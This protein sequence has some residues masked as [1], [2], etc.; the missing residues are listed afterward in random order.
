MPRAG[1]TGSGFGMKE[2]YTPCSIATSLITSRK[3]M[4]LSAVRQRVGV[5]Q[6]DLLLARR[7]LVVAELHRDAHRLE[8]RDGL[9]AEVVADAVR[10]RSK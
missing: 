6:V 9:A 8:M 1:V 10:V 4:M 5:A 3:V 2:A 7:R